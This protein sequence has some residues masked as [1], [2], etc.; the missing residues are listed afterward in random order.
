MSALIDGYSADAALY[1]RHWAPVLAPTA[2]RLLD[3]LA[4]HIAA[5]GRPARILDVG[6]GTGALAVA[7]AARW[8]DATVVVSEPAQG[9]L[10]LAR[11][12]AAAAGADI[13]GRLEFAI[14]Q[15]GQLPVADSS[16]D[17]VVSS[18]VFQLVPDR[19]A[20]LREAARVLSPGGMLAYVTWL[21]RDGRRP[22]RP[23]DEFD[24][25]VLDLG[26]DEPEPPPQEHAG[27][28][29][30][31]RAAMGEL[32]RA[33]FADVL[34]RADELVHA[35]TA[36][37][38]LDYKLGYDELFLLSLLGDD[39]RQRLASDARRRLARLR[40]SDFR[41]HAPIVIARGV[42]PRD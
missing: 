40:E 20:A 36:E 27:D 2:G 17:A 33:G 22:F 11:Q 14:G 38:Y 31:P 5:L 29:E 18:F 4:D 42:K 7:A 12:R 15:A 8:P 26:I 3:E 28:V 39:Q 25:A 34:A 9:M 21:D 35:W 24:A 23:G 30:S 37:S 19:D 32:R 6:A 16:V 41:W 10:E 1:L 13:A